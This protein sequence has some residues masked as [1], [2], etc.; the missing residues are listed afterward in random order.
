MLGMDWIFPY[1]IIIDYYANIVNLRCMVFQGLSG[2]VLKLV[3]IATLSPSFFPKDQ[4][5]ECVYPT[6]PLLEILVASHILWISFF[7]L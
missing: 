5:K 3:F 1:H 2:R 4:W 6:W 7:V